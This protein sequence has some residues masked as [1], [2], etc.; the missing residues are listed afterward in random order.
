MDVVVAAVK[1]RSDGVS[2]DADRRGA[3]NSKKDSV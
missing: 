2:H 3:N 1:R